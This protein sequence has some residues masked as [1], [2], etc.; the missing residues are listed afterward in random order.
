MDKALLDNILGGMAALVTCIAGAVYLWK[1]PSRRKYD[2]EELVTVAEYANANDARL[3]KMRLESQGVP[4]FIVGE[5]IASR[6]S[7]GVGDLS[8]IRLQV[9]GCDVGRARRILGQS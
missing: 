1:H 9:L 7:I 2:P 4:C 3:W 8:S 6:A 5:L